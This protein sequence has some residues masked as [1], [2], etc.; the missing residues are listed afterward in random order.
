MSSEQY[1]LAVALFV[2]FEGTVRR[3]AF[4][5]THFVQFAELFRDLF[6]LLYNFLFLLPFLF[7]DKFVQFAHFFGNPAAYFGSCRL[8]FRD[9]FD[10]LFEE[11]VAVT[12]GVE[13]FELGFG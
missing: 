4:E 5:A 11:F 13:Y 9:E 2:A 10:V 1:G 3:A 6:E 12:E 7:D 8:Y